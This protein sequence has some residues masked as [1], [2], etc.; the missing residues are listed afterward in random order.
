MTTKRR[1]GKEELARRGQAL[2][3]NDVLPKLTANDDGK[4]AALDV[5]SGAY[6]IDRDKLA[7]CDRLRARLPDAQIWMVRVGSRYVS[8]FGGR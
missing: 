5:E 4:F 2:Y 3:E 1:Y 6:E 8:R 7:A